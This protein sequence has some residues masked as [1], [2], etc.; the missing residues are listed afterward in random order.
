MTALRSAANTLLYLINIINFLCPVMAWMVG[1]GTPA[2]YRL[3]TEQW[4]AGAWAI[5]GGGAATYPKGFCGET[6]PMG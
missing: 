4:L 6:T 2:R 3:E 1:I 5:A